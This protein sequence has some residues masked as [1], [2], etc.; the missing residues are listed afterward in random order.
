MCFRIFILVFF[1]TM[2]VHAQHKSVRYKMV[3]FIPECQP[4]PASKKANKNPKHSKPYALKKLIVVSQN[5]IDTITTD[6]NGYIKT[7]WEYGTYYLFEPWKFYKQVPPTLLE[8]NYDK[9]CL[10]E[11]WRKEDL[12]IVVSKKT[13]TI[14]NNLILLECPDKHPCLTNQVK[15][16]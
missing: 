15:Q 6:K 3:Q 12:K 11:E 8:K 2:S 4:H 1:F 7:N 5:H 16:Q 9:T 14:A 13:T 10:D